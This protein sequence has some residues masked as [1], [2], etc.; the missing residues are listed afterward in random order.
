MHILAYDL[1]GIEAIRTNKP[2]KSIEHYLD[3]NYRLL[4]EE[5][6]RNLCTGIQNFR[7]DETQQMKIYRYLTMFRVITEPCKKKVSVPL[8]RNEPVEKVKEGLQSVLR[9]GSAHNKGGP[10][11]INIVQISYFSNSFGIETLVYIDV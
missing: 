5:C 4:R 7:Y 6:F 2:Y 11:N 10:P 9:I 3:I 8:R 1:K